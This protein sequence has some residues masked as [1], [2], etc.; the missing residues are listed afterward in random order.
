M[1]FARL[2]DHP[3]MGAVIT[4]PRIGAWTANVV[5]D[6]QE[7]L[8]GAVELRA[9]GVAWA[10]TAV[11]TGVAQDT[12]RAAIVGGAGGL[13][14]QVSP[15]FY[16]DTTA[17]IVVEDILSAVG[18]MLSQTS[19]A[20][21]LGKMLAAW[22]RAG[23]KA[24]AAL[25]Q[26]VEP[27]GA[28]W[29]VLADGSIWVGQESWP[30]AQLEHELVAED[31]RAGWVEIATE[32]L[33]LTPGTMFRGRMVAK[34]EHR[35]SATSVR[36]RCWFADAQAEDPAEAIAALV[37]HHTAGS[38]Y[39]GQFPARVVAQ[40]GDG[41]LELQPDDSRLPG[42]S[43]VPIRY[44]LPGVTVEVLAGARVAI[45]FEAGDPA[46]PVATVW[47][48]GTVTKMVIASAAEVTVNAPTVNVGG[49][50]SAVKLADGTPVQGVARIGDQ[51]QAGPF[52]G[53]VLKGSTL[54]T[55]GG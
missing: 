47:E 44:G 46:R 52:G 27:Y 14:L 37:R 34:V 39:L 42:M 13:S 51:V 49:A 2:A 23:G 10:G 25:R 35:V 3:V 20:A 48:S 1:S 8:S 38:L 45:E 50:T 36:T 30:E 9:G 31:P 24:G 16:R 12:V 26:F 18:E 11:R 15:K 29:R 7:D 40:N 19:D 4:M 6:A 21:F 22:S 53:V 17:R 5:A 28:A 54:V 41:S 43:K 32:D 33:S 55:A